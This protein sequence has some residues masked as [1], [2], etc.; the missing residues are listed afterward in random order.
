MADAILTL[1]FP[2]K[3]RQEA[4][5]LGLG[6][7]FTG[8]ACLNGHIDYRYLSR[9]CVS[10]AA[11]TKA[12]MRARHAQN[13]AKYRKR[14]VEKERARQAL[15]AAN[16]KEK[17]SVKNAEWRS[18]NKDSYLAVKAWREKN[19]ERAN[20]MSRVWQRKNRD[21]TRAYG[22]NRRAKEVANGG[23]L[24]AGIAQKLWLAQRGKCACCGKPLGK[25]FHIDHIMPIALG[26]PNTDDNVQ[27][28]TQRCNNQKGAKHPIDF[29]RQRGFLI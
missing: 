1:G 27:L 8:V 2:V 15:Y 29:M 9:G 18:K 20:E 28:L 14:D 19:R 25:S 13:S 16:N 7:Y 22:Q 6:K 11:R 24:S 4:I 26:G 12:D 17:I 23:R 10:C 21:K 5:A 3:T